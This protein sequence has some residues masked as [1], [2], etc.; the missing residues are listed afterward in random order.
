[1]GFLSN[2]YQPL[3]VLLLQDW[4]LKMEAVCSPEIFVTIY[5]TT[6][7]HMPEDNYRVFKGRENFQMSYIKNYFL[8]H[9]LMCSWLKNSWHAWYSEVEWHFN[10]IDAT[11]KIFI[12]FEQVLFSL[13]ARSVLNEQLT[14]RNIPFRQCFIILYIIWF[15]CDPTTRIGAIVILTFWDIHKTWT[16]F[17][18]TD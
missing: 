2:R 17:K 11:D 14:Y 6:P 10:R 13:S 15:Q 18:G 1:M 7:H 3:L 9:F 4:P 8:Q 16:C 12:F 5:Q